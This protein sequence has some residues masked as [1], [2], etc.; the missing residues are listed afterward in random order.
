MSS[1]SAGILL[2]IAIL[3]GI[4]ANAAI[5]NAAQDITDENPELAD[6]TL[7]LKAAHEAWQRSDEEYRKFS[8][9]GGSPEAEVQEFAA[10]VV[11]LQIRAF[12]SSEV[13]RELGGD[14]SQYYETPEMRKDAPDSR[15]NIASPFA[16]RP[17]PIAKRE[18]SHKEQVD[19]LEKKLVKVGKTFD[20]MIRESQAGIRGVA[21]NGQSNG[22]WAGGVV[23]E[24]GS[25][26]K[27]G[28]QQAVATSGKNEKAEPGA[29]IGVA[30]PVVNPDIDINSL[31]DGSDDD[32][33][34]R[35]LREAAHGARLA[36]ELTQEEK[37]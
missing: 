20:E 29:G 7:G 3:C 33:L 6:A 5:T 32:K 37:G 15:E 12:D 9:L 14:V 35:Q 34:A 17:K 26:A 10:F 13:V 36:G 22:G 30:K 23:G 16:K 28:E 2:R 4:V 11:E 18:L 27:S 21:V 25:K 31:G 1:G 8:K 24:P 19:L